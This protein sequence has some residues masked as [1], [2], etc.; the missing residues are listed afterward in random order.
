MMQKR[1]GSLVWGLLGTLAMICAVLLSGS[2]A[3]ADTYGVTGGDGSTITTFYVQSWGSA[4]ITLTQES[5]VFTSTTGGSARAWGRYHVDCSLNGASQRLEWKDPYKDTF[6]IRMNQAGLYKISLTPY[7]N[8]EMSAE[9]SVFGSWKVL[10]TWSLTNT[11]NCQI[12]TAP[13]PEPVTGNYVTVY[14]RDQY[15]KQIGMRTVYCSVGSNT[16]TAP[17]TLQN[18]RF[19][20]SSAS[21]QVVTLTAGG[22]LSPAT[23]TFY[24]AEAAATPA[25]TQQPI[26]TASCT[27]YYRDV[28]GSLLSTTSYTCRTGSNTITAPATLSVNGRSYSRISSAS[29]SVTLY[30][31]GSL[32]ATSVTFFYQITSTPTPAPATAT[33]YIYYRDS[34]GNLLQSSSETMT[35]GTRTFTAPSTLSVNGRTYKLYTAQSQQVTLYASGSLS[36]SSLTF[37]YQVQNTPTPAPVTA[38]VYIYY[39]DSSGNMLQSSSETMTVGT[40]TFTA[41]ATLSVG[42]RTYKLYTAQSQQVTLYANGTLSASSLSFYYQ[43]QNTP[44]PVPATATIYIYYRDNAGNLLQTDS[45]TITVGTHTITAPS[46]LWVSSRNYQLIPPTSQQVTLYQNGAVSA[47]SVTFYYQRE[48]TP[49]PVTASV[50]IYYRDSYGSILQQQSETMTVGTRTFTAPATLSAGGKT[51]NLTSTGSQSVTLYSDGTLSASSVDFYYQ[52]YN[53]V[54]AT[55]TVQKIDVDTMATLD[56]RSETLGVGTHTIKAGNTPSGYDLYDASTASVTVYENGNVSQSVV[57]FRY[58]RKATTPPVTPVPVTPE[59]GQVIPT[60]WDTQFKD[61]SLSPR[62]IN[63]LPRICDGN[64]GRSFYYTMWASEQ[65]DDIPEITITFGPGSDIASV[66]IAVGELN[67]ST[68][69]YNK[70]RPSKMEFVV[71]SDEG[72]NRTT[73]EI[74][75]NYDKRMVP[76]SFNTLYHNVT[77]IEVFITNIWV[78]TQD[79]Y[80]VHIAEMSFYDR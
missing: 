12:S 69:F 10:P 31:S 16:I 76:Y 18:G 14:Y 35:V 52:E 26:S 43:L 72:V 37:Y 40:R 15:G 49:A 53:P 63:T 44:T 60:S 27:V 22:V 2:P 75:R 80:E 25:P 8:P 70:A 13:T 73:F 71:Y 65:K 38:T 1:F 46:T 32:S 21:T 41:P 19:Y 74:P 9:V 42:G 34:A 58:R 24:Y 28:Y 78:G 68:Y 56:T 17:Q 50:R 39:R 30:A 45:K 20:L 3:H 61:G 77:K 48:S 23:V 67:T 51:Y 5:G 62:S 55:I 66:W 29:Q 64:L 7:T 54:T 6:V 47:N 11:Q 59:E 57:T 36:T 4:T 33:V 79:R